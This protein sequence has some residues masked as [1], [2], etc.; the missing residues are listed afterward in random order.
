MVVLGIENQIITGTFQPMLKIPASYEALVKSVRSALIEGQKRIEAERVR[1]YWETGRLINEHVLKHKDRADY[2][3]RVIADLARDLHVDRSQ[4]NRCVRFYKQYP[5]LPIGGARPKLG[6][7]HYRK[8]IAVTDDRER[9]VLEKEASRNQWSAEELAQ[10]I[11][12]GREDKPHKEPAKKNDPPLKPLPSLIPLT[13]LRGELYTYRVITRPTVGA[14]EVSGLLIDLGF[15]IFRE[16]ESRAVAENDIVRSSKRDDN[17]RLT[18]IDATA[19]TLFTYNG[20][21]E[22][23]IDA[24]TLKVRLDLGFGTFSRHDLRLRGIDC[25]EMSTKAGEEAKVFVQSYIKEAQRIVVRSSRSDKYD[26][27]LADVFLP[28]DEGKGIYLN[29]LLLENNHAVRM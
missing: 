8:L 7:T 29:N 13:P 14:G 16:C 5:A 3:A 26:R 28:S 6:W 19:S 1:T 22:R 27:Y 11:K 20:Y 2:G 15:G 25:P 4:I 23:V 21:V 18:K 9:M 10:R 12:R 24:D 17:Y